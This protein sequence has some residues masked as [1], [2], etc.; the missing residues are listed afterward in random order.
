MFLRLRKIYAL[1]DSS[2]QFFLN[3]YNTYMLPGILNIYRRIIIS[4]SYRYLPI[5]IIL[6]NIKHEFCCIDG[7]EQDVLN[8][9]INIKRIKFSLR[10]CSSFTLSLQKKGSCFLKSSDFLVRDFCY[11]LNPNLIISRISNCFSI[12]ITLNIKKVSSFDFS[13]V[14]YPNGSI[15]ISSNTISI[16]NVSFGNNTHYSFIKI[17]TDRTISPISCFLRSSLLLLGCFKFSPSNLNLII[18][19][20][21][22]LYSPYMFCNINKLPISDKLYN[23]FYLNKIRCL[24]N[25]LLFTNHNL[26]IYKPLSYKKLFLIY[27]L[28]KLG[29]YIL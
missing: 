26:T 22:F 11:I 4:K 15:R 28:Y 24:V 1:K 19:N 2:L 14:N 29:F 6:N 21:S 10:N 5:Y 7:L 12:F 9:I 23:L 16:K 27:E 17:E 18:S 13:S 25:I 8:L 3:K 20:L